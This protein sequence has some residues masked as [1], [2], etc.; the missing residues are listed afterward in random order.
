[1]C[2]CLGA[3]AYMCMHS[4][5]CRAT[6]TRTAWSWPATAT[7][8]CT[9]ASAA[10]VRRLCARTPQV[11]GLR[12]PHGGKYRRWP[13]WYVTYVYVCMHVCPRHNV[14]YRLLMF[15]W[16]PP[17]DMCTF[18]LTTLCASYKQ[19]NTKKTGAHG[20]SGTWSHRQ[21]RHHHVVWFIEQR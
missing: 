15:F 7:P 6:L 4:V 16:L 21:G 5:P 10:W 2:V 13:K 8:T 11:F 1:M 9:A 12:D 19:T 3:R 18:K 17:S 20:V 14:N